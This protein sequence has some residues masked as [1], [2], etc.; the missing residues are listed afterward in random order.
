MVARLQRTVGDG[1]F[2]T[3]WWKLQLYGMEVCIAVAIDGK[4]A[5]AYMCNGGYTP[6]TSLLPSM[7]CDGGWCAWHIA[8]HRV[9]QVRFGGAEQ[10]GEAELQPDPYCEQDVVIS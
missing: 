9:R 8:R 1:G 7:V 3:M 10:R 6:T 5:T 4:A 2:N